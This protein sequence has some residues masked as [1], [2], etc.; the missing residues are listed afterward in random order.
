MTTMTTAAASEA[1]ALNQIAAAF[2]A[3][4][5]VD[6]ARQDAFE[7]DAWCRDNMVTRS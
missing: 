5:T 3:N 1:D 2:V 4:P 7:V 6:Q